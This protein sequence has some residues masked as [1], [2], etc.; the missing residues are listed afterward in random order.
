MPGVV[1]LYRVLGVSQTAEP[2]EIRAGYKTAVKRVHP[3][4]GGTHEAFLLVDAAR[5]ILL[6]SRDRAGYDR[7]L[8][9]DT[10]LRSK[11]TVDSVAKA[12]EEAI[13]QVDGWDCPGSLQ[14]GVKATLMTAATWLSE[15]PSG[16]PSPG[17]TDEQM[18]YGPE[19]WSK[20]AAPLRARAASRMTSWP[21]TAHR[22]ESASWTTDLR[23]RLGE[24]CQVYRSLRAVQEVLR[25][26]PV[27]DADA[28]FYFHTCVAL[29]TVSAS[30]RRHSADA[31]LSY[32]VK[33]AAWL[34]AHVSRAESRLRRRGL[35]P[36][37]APWTVTSPRPT[38]SN[39]QKDAHP[40]ETAEESQ[41]EAPNFR[42]DDGNSDRPSGHD[43]H[44]SAKSIAALLGAV[45]LAIALAIIL[46]WSGSET[47]PLTFE[48]SI[49]QTEVVCTSRIP[50][51]E[52]ELQ[53]G[54]ELDCELLDTRP[55]NEDRPYVEVSVNGCARVRIDGT[56][57]ADPVSRT[58]LIE[59]CGA[60][61]SL[62]DWRVCQTHGGLLPDDCTWGSIKL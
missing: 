32:A 20:R 10:L 44:L 28:L 25:S 61:I 15:N 27:T 3:D 29:V 12:L 22:L 18:P 4:V 13:N 7:I 50:I 55:G 39:A 36:G 49:K 43:G 58:A 11:P 46:L 16:R 56:D 34:D 9:L 33:S 19:Y 53:V 31:G 41:R 59:P 45:G 40:H 47:Q 60:P 14:D 24:A 52:D 48:D 54:F 2:D 1:D 26:D 21:T 38:E 42:N 57:E 62:L 35:A 37:H 5:R 23:T 17:N 51:G 30:I 8:V 6:N